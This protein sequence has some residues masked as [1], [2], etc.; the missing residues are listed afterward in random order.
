MSL[1]KAASYWLAALACAPFGS[2]FAADVG[3]QAETGT[4]WRYARASFNAALNQGG[5][6]ENFDGVIAPALPVGWS[7]TNAIAGNGTRWHTL[8]STAPTPLSEPNAAFVDAH[9]GISDKRLDS[10]PLRVISLPASIGFA[11]YG[12]VEP[13]FDGMVLELSINGGDFLDA[14]AAGGSFSSGRYD[15][16]IS[17]GFSSPIAGRA[18][19]TRSEREFIATSYLLASTIAVGDELR[20]RWRVATDN[21]VSGSGFH[22]DNFVASGLQLVAALTADEPALTA[23]ALP[24]PSDFPICAGGFFLAT[25]ADGNATGLSAG[26]Y[27]LALELL[28]SGDQRFEGG[29]N[30]G[31]LLDRSQP[32]SARFSIAAGADDRQPLML[33]LNGHPTGSAILDLPVSVRVV[34]VAAA[35]ADVLI[36]QSDSSLSMTRVYAESLSLTPGDYVITVATRDTSAIPGGPADGEIFASLTTQSMGGPGGAVVRGIEIGGY[37]A[38]SL[39]SGVSGYASLCLGVRHSLNVRVF[40]APTYGPEGA[41]DLRI[42]LLDHTRRELI[43]VP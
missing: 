33:L 34:R 30:F 38:P 42:Q 24:Q 3:P 31:G 7:A 20:F 8:A 6:Q 39:F 17:T 18:A 25:V 5:I 10:P 32:L 23:F 27:G 14:L 15:G 4:E 28:V 12:D 43:S 29:F 16:S 40:A 22:L 21:S 1:L 37:H 13:G 19:W 9:A 35:A 36:F 26:R 41:Q 11:R 2:L